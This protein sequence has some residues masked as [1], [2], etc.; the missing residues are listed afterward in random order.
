MGVCS[1]GGAGAHSQDGAA[2]RRP[3]PGQRRCARIP[4]LPGRRVQGRRAAMPA[5][6]AA[7]RLEL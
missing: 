6:T 7:A 1:H 5:A 2:G 3:P 4:S